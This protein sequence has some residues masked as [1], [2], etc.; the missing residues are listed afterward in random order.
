MHNYAQIDLETK[1]VVGVSQL[2]EEV[3]TNRLIPISEYDTRLL[4]CY[5]INGKF[6]G[7]Y[8]KLQYNNQK[9]I[10]EVFTYLDEKAIDYNNDVVFEYEGE[11]ITVQAVN[12]VAEIDFIGDAGTTHT[13]CTVNDKFR[14]GEVK[15][16]V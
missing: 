6:E 5:Y 13:V 9:V 11:R 12:G 10:A 14:N 3:N 1:K 7:Y 16:S 15:F 4:I 2:S 8:T